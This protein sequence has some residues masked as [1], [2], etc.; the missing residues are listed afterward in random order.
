LFLAY[1][2]PFQFR[3]HAE[4]QAVYVAAGQRLLTGE[5]IYQ[6]SGD[7]VGFVYPPFAA[8]IA[9]PFALLTPGVGRAAWYLLNVVC[10]VVLLRSAWQLSGGRRL[11]GTPSP[12]PR[13]HL[14]CIL[15]LACSLS[16]AI[17]CLAHQQTDL[18]IA[19]LMMAGCLAL[20]QSRSWLAATAFGLAAA[21]KC[22]PLLWGPYLFWRGRWR[23]A[24]W[25]GCVAL[26]ANLLPNLLSAPEPGKLYLADWAERYLLP[27]SRPEYY[28]GT[29]YTAPIFNQSLPGTINRWALTYCHLTADDCEILARS[30]PL[31][32]RTVKLL[33]YAGELSLL[34]GLVWILGR[35]PFAEGP[36]PRSAPAEYSCVLLFMLFLSPMSNTQHFVTLILPA[37]YLAR[38]AVERR[39][40]TPALL[41]LA[42]IA[43][44]STVIKWL[45]GEKFSSLCLW[46][47]SVT[48]SALLLLVG[49][50]CVLLAARSEAGSYREHG[51]LA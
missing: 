8:L 3:Q 39:Q 15:G 26:G 35:R 7:Y 31:P 14:I 49:C 11:E 50:A 18:V 33:V 36:E 40:L 19:A 25:L 13:E 38:L 47:G 30:E 5:H 34:L 46:C 22:T 27:M 12:P 21:I 4:W 51:G 42:A 29:W 43:V 23:E 48:W 32:A 16:Y 2:V 37:F 1:A 41:L 45:W 28:P 44:R 17:N 20:S 6:C 24:A 9:A 10:L